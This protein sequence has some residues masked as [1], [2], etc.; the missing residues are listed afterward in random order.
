MAGRASGPVTLNFANA[1]I[2]AVARTMATITGRNV[3][4]DPRVKGTMTVVTT[5]PVTPTQALRLFSVQLRT[6]GFALVE[7]A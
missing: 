7:S 3:V 1:E 4:V 2:D 5:S 6:Q